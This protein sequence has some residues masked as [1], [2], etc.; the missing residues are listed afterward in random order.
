MDTLIE[1]GGS[2][3]MVQHSG[4]PNTNFGIF[5]SALD[6][7]WWYILNPFGTFCVHLI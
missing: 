2:P 7:K 1:K 5:V 4:L 6:R 3:A